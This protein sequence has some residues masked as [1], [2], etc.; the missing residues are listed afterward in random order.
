[1]PKP[2]TMIIAEMHKISGQEL[3]QLFVQAAR[4]EEGQ[5][6]SSWA[7]DMSHHAEQDSA[8]REFWRRTF[9]T[10][11]AAPGSKNA[12][13]AK[14]CSNSLVFPDAVPNLPEINHVYDSPE[15]REGHAVHD[16]CAHR[17][18]SSRARQ[19]HGFVGRF[20]SGQ[21]VLAR[22]ASETRQVAAPQGAHYHA[23]PACAL[24]HASPKSG[25]V[26]SR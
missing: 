15:P 14:G 9:S 12:V 13:E 23:C 20:H 24:P 5:K 11:F 2:N 6:L 19:T 16:Q 1:M 4:R 7:L 17:D 26:G 3:G 8:T 22:Q 18:H 10:R 25:Y 21:V